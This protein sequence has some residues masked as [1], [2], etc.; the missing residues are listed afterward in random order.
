MGEYFKNYKDTDNETIM[1]QSW[2][3][4]SSLTTLAQSCNA[5]GTLSRA[6]LP[7]IYSFIMFNLYRSVAICSF[8]ILRQMLLGLVGF[9]GIN[10]VTFNELMLNQIE[11]NSLKPPYITDLLNSCPGI[12]HNGTCSI[13]VAYPNHS[14][15]VIEQ[16][17]LDHECNLNN[18]NLHLPSQTTIVDTTFESDPK[19]LKDISNP[20]ST[21]Y[22]Q[23]FVDALPESEL[24][25]LANKQK[26]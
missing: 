9:F 14:T 8:T 2:N 3:G 16:V 13:R 5:N 10:Y 20:F 11:G 24:K 25:D 21:D 4:T 7:G 15:V 23:K 1:I 17:T 12:L 18:S 22:L 6:A 19:I 26:L